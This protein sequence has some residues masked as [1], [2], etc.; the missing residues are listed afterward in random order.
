MWTL[1]IRLCTSILYVEAV[2]IS[3]ILQRSRSQL[4]GIILELRAWNTTN[5]YTL[6]MQSGVLVRTF[7]LLYSN[8]ERERTIRYL[9]DHFSFFTLK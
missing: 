3:Y 9:F 6:I 7:I 5:N 8:V 4:H 2:K 1:K